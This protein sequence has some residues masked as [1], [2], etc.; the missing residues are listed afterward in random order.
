M[1]FPEP[2]PKDIET[3]PRALES[4]ILLWC[5]DEGGWHSGEWFQGRW[6]SSACL[7]EV[8]EPTH[9]LPLPPDP[10]ID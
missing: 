5:P 8:L 4:R 1:S 3:A 9:W 7:T 10:A 2:A 6:V